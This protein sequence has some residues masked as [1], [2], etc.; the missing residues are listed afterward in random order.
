MK[1]VEKGGIKSMILKGREIDYVR[2]DSENNI[3]II[4]GDPSPVLDKSV[5]GF[6]S[7]LIAD[8][9]GPSPDAE[10][11]VHVV[12]KDGL[13]VEEKIVQEST[14]ADQVVL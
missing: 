1:V 2:I 5:L 6:R 3:V 12:D 9:S 13:K 11:K 8:T 4:F 14:P 10:F 7:K